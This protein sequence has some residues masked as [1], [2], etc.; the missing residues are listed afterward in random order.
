MTAYPDLTGDWRTIALELCREWRRE[1]AAVLRGWLGTSWRDDRQ[2]LRLSIGDDE[3][4][5]ERVGAEGVQSV[6]RILLA[7]ERRLASLRTSLP[8]A[9]AVLDRARDI[10]L[11]FPRRSVLRLSLELPAASRANLRKA[12]AFELEQLSPIAPDKL[13]FDLDVTQNGPLARVEL[14]AIKRSEVDDARALCHAAKLGVGAIA[15]EGDRRE[16]DW[17]AFPVD[18]LA[19]LRR[20]WRLRGAAIAAVA[21]ALLLA[22][23]LGA[24]ALRNAAELDALQARLQDAD[25][26]L[27]SLHRMER[28]I[29]DL[30]TQ[31]EFPAAQ[32][33]A[34]LVIGVLAELSRVLPDGTWLTEFGIKDGRAHMRGLSRAP[35]D[36]IAAIDQSPRFTNAQFSAPLEGAQNGSERFE[37]TF[38]VKGAP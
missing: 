7:G 15:F 8:E 24:F 3:L 14:R 33:R 6:A 19:W 10:V 25:L 4:A 34:P 26:Q 11:R 27:A 38:D 1:I 20:H 5:L 17:R 28:N 13:Y 18:P 32:K 21:A 37:L 23:L 22:G 2:Y 16:A 30:R 29:S 35:A 12:A 31:I 36:L 9:Q